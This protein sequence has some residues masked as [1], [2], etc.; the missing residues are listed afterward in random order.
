[1]SLLPS[2]TPSPPPISACTR[3]LNQTWPVGAEE[4]EEESEEE[5][6]AEGRV[7]QLFPDTG[8][9]SSPYRQA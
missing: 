1:M 2:K 3:L 7:T 6:Y 4:E 5:E 8:L 9:P